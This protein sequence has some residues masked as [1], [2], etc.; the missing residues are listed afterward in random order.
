MPQTISVSQFANVTPGVLAAGGAA[1]DLTGLIV[2]GSTRVPL[3]SVVSFPTQA[4][5]SAY[6]GASS[7]EAAL[8][9]NYFLAN[10]NSLAKPGALLFA[11][12]NAAAV[13]AYLRGGTLTVDLTTLKTYTGTI[14]ITV[15]GVAKTSSSINL[16]GATSFSNAATIIQAAFTSPNF[17][18]TYDSVSAAFVFTSNTTGASSTITLATGTAVD[19]LKLTAATG[20]VTSQGAIAATPS[21]AMTAIRGVT[22]GFAA[23]TTT[24]EPSSADKVLFAAWSNS[25]ANK[26]AYLM[27][28]TAVAPLSSG[29]TTSAGYLVRQAGYSGVTPIWAANVTNG[30]AVAAFNLGVI[31]GL[32][33]EQTNGRTTFAF[34]QQSGLTPDVTDSTIAANLIT[35]GYNYYGAYANA[36]ASWNLF[37]NGS[38]T[39]PFLWLDT[40]VNQIWLNAAL[41]ADLVNL[42]I[43]AGSIPYNADGKGLIEAAVQDTVGTAVDFGA[44]RGG[45]TLSA[46]QI[47]QVN[48]AAGAKISDTLQ[49]RGWYLKVGDASAATRTARGSPPCTFWYVDG[50]SVQ[51]INL[52]SIEL[53]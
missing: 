34:R 21:G 7:Q 43:S 41:Q 18:V 15:D 44:I 26:I 40:Y 27:W 49:Q 36:S 14:T 30:P 50:Q 31:A 2:T 5:V 23:F 33:F 12:Y 20:A 10:D 52:A 1:Q 25:Q 45:V 37:Y 13:S 39:G 51:A 9:S 19:L 32:D 4:A 48:Q 24:F 46:V 6:F 22:Q 17:A 53:Q 42:L 38:V 28:D 3:G 11:Q 16:S 8:A 47:A 29:D 35:N